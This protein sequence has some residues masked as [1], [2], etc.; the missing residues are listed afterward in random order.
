MCDIFYGVFHYLVTFYGVTCASP[1]SCHES[2]P[3][4][5]SCETLL[6]ISFAHMLEQRKVSSYATKL[7]LRPHQVGVAEA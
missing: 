6:L 7:Q 3:S 1:D 2:L 5:S 4:C